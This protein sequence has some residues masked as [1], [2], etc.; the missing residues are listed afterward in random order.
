MKKA[1]MFLI[2]FLILS[3]LF[4]AE[5]IFTKD[6]FYIKLNSFSGSDYFSGREYKSMN[7]FDRHR[8]YAG[9]KYNV[10]NNTEIWFDLT[11]DDKFY[12]KEILL[13]RIGVS[14]KKSAFTY[15]YKIDRLQYGE[16]SE[17]YNIQVKDRFYDFGVMEDYRYNGIQIDYSQ[18]LFSSDILLAANDFNSAIINLAMNLETEI[19]F[20]EIFFLAVA[21][22][23]EYNVRNYSLGYETKLKIGNF[24]IYASGVYQNLPTY[25]KG[26][27]F[28][29]LLEFTYKINKNLFIGSNYFIEDF[30]DISNPN[31]QSQSFIKISVKKNE[32]TFFHRKNSMNEFIRNYKN[33]EY[34]FLHQYRFTNNLALGVNYSYFNPN[35]DQEYHQIGFQINYHY[36][37]DL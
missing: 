10:I 11:F 34:A 26:D 32:F 14:Y 23:E 1:L 29:Q 4:S 17:I 8:F 13:N 22:N 36:E 7:Y 18:E 15:S 31:K 24:G 20:T 9:W 12:E 21:R 33:E 30:M 6:N 5:S 37:K 28:K 35:F 2:F 16:K 25:Y 27:K 3:S 19:F